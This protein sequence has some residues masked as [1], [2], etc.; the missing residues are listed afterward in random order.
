MAKGGK[1]DEMQAIII[2]KVIKKG[3]GH[4][5][6]AWKVAY[7]DFV[8]AMM[9][10]FLLLWLLNVSTDEALEVISSYFDPSHPKIADTRSGAGGIMGGLTMSKEGAMAEDRQPPVAQQNTGTD[11]KTMEVNKQGGIADSDGLKKLEDELRNK[12][13]TR[14]KEAQKAL[15]K[16]LQSSEEL[17]ELAKHLQI[18]VTPEGL[19]IQIIDQEGEPMFRSGS[20][21]MVAKARTL[22]ETVADVIQTMPND[23][24]VRGHT[25]SHK[26]SPGATYTNWELSADRANAAR[27]VLLEKSVAISRLNDVMGKADREHLIAENP[28]DARNRRISIIMLRETVEHAFRR[29]AFDDQIPEDN[30]LEDY[31]DFED[32]EDNLPLINDKPAGTFQKSPGNVYFP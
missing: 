6:G 31:D 7:A 9:A 3:G 32:Y 25:D 16:A 28:L 19:R 13:E 11:R 12:E 5:G 24:S 22:M 1:Q 23:I 30:R 18:D 20:A 21:D 17:K 8:T 27:R 10:F 14:F 29:G 2:K 26:Y 4:H 15:E